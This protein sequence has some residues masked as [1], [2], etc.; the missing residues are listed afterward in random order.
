MI[1]A[2]T[3][4]SCIKASHVSSADLVREVPI[5]CGCGRERWDGRA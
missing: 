3:K 2:Q 1:V 5:V 4:S